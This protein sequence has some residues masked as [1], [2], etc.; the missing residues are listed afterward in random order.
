MANQNTADYFAKNGI[1]IKFDNP[2]KISH[3]KLVIIDDGVFIGSANWNYKSL[4]INT[5]AN[6]FTTNPQAVNKFKTYFENIWGNSKGFN[7]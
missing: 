4:A 2:Y 6:I 1:I 5:E 3:A 7:D